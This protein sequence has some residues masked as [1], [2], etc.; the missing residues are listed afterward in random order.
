MKRILSALTA[1]AVTLSFVAVSAFASIP[2]GDRYNL[3]AVTA[4]NNDSQKGWSVD[5][6]DGIPTDYSLEAFKAARYLVLELASPPVGGVQFIIQTDGDNW[7]WN[8]TNGIVGDD[9]QSEAVI[10]IDLTA[11]EG[12]SALQAAEEAAKIFVAYYSN[13][14][15][16]LGITSAY[17]VG[18]FG[19]GGAAPAVVQDSVAGDCDDDDCDDDHDHG[20]APAPAP[21]APAASPAT[22]NTPVIAIVSLMALAG[23][24]AIVSKKRK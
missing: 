4:V 24:A 21:V 1:C 8:Q 16:D 11:M 14:F 17:F 2:A 13:G 6:T 19:G 12:Y 15:D 18:D 22:G 20:T 10:V 5:G 9:G 23:V 3:G 7:G